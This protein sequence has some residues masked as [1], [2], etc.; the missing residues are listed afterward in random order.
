MSKNRVSRRARSGYHEAMND[1]DRVE[2]AVRRIADGEGKPPTLAE[3]A[4]GAGLSPFHFHRVFARW[5]RVTP[6]ALERFLAGERA[7]ALLRGGR[8][9][10]EAALETGLSGPGR[11]HD[12]LVRVEAVT[13][14]E[15]KSGGAG[16]AIAWGFAPTPFGTALIGV[17]ARGICHLAF[18]DGARAAAL[19]DLRRKWPRADL[20]Q[21]AAAARRAAARVFGRGRRSVKALL[22]GTPFQLK[23]WEALLRVPPGRALGYGALAAR[24]GRPKAARAVGSAVGSNTVGWLIPCH[25]VL[26]EAGGLGGY[27]WGAARKRAMLLREAL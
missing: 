10:L 3:L 4:R 6:K 7:K 9:A 18:A 20:Y 26:R 21:D 13:P 14:G 11:L 1:Y 16:V 23:V 22:S 5:A 24:L 2:K 17:T 15:Y 25:R 19:A 27:R 12:L 8:P